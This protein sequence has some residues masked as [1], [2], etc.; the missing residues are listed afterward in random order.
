MTGK[1]YYLKYSINKLPNTA[2]RQY[3]MERPK[4]DERQIKILGIVQD[5]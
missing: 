3:P 5:L 2:G 1:L 4:V